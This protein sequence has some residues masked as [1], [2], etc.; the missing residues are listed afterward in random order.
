MEEVEVEV[1]VEQIQKEKKKENKPSDKSAPPPPAFALPDWID[2][3]Q[4]DLWMKTRKGKKM[5][6]EQMQAQIA[7]M[8]KWRDDGLDYCGAL[9]NAAANGY[10][11]LFLP[12]AKKSPVTRQTENDRVREAARK[13]LFGANEERVIEPI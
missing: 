11:G 13:I 4:W 2:K 10:T 3:T 7:K 5:I 8:G 1:E 6:A 12:D 9:A